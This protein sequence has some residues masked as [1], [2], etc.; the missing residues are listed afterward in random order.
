MTKII[1]RALGAGLL[2]LGLG[3]SG[4]T[5]RV[6]AQGQ[7]EKY[8]SQE[9]RLN[10]W[11]TSA[12]L[13]QKAGTPEFVAMRFGKHDGFD[14]VVFEL[15]G[16]WGGYH[17]T[18]DRPPFDVDAGSDSVKVRGNAFV[19]VSLYPVSSTDEQVEA[20]DKLA[21]QQAKLDM[22]VIRDVQNIEWFEGELAYAFGLKRRT[23][24]RVQ[25]F[26]NPTRL[27][28]DFRH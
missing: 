23:P 17:V 20:N 15:K 1:S 3:F 19:R 24:F 13:R 27:V 9:G 12:V 4:F 2:L 21:A 28:V 18:Y 14:R 6:N 16:E 8:Y 26:S 11:T 7:A 5:S 10:A 25:V 22:P